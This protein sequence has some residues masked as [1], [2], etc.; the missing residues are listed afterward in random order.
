M[1]GEWRGHLPRRSADG[2]QAVLREEYYKNMQRET[3]TRTMIG[4]LW[5]MRSVI[6]CG[7]L[8]GHDVRIAGKWVLLENT[9]LRIVSRNKTLVSEL[10]SI[11][12]SDRHHRCD[13]NN[14][15]RVNIRAPDEGRGNVQSGDTQ[16][17]C[18]VQVQQ[19]AQAFSSLNRLVKQCPAE[20][21][22]CKKWR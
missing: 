13:G 4:R 9:E 11:L 10:K 14:G 7:K 6:I 19:F 16:W 12:L 1:V 22:Y 15:I 2:C 21:P 3:Y 20:G 5:T 18:R 8:L 17:T